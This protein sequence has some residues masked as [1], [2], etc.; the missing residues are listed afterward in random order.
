MTFRLEIRQ[1]DLIIQIFQLSILFKQINFNSKLS[2]I[3]LLSVNKFEQIIRRYDNTA[4]GFG[5]FLYIHTDNF[6]GVVYEFRAVNC[7]ILFG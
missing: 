2:V 7:V 4:Q 6:K 3:F 1:L 5:S